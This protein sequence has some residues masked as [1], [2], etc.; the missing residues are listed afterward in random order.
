MGLSKG[1]VPAADEFTR[2]AR[3]LYPCLTWEELMTEAGKPY[4]M[5][6]Q[7]EEAPRGWA[8]WF[9]EPV[10]AVGGVAD[11]GWAVIAAH[12]AD[13]LIALGATAVEALEDA[14][15]CIRSLLVA[16]GGGSSALMRYLGAMMAPR[17]G[18]DNNSL[19]EVA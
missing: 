6:Y 17:G 10:V 15:N 8:C 9:V 3:G 16:T 4:L 11:A 18:E 5:V 13:E 1:I 14:T 7:P 12:E 2:V 19:E